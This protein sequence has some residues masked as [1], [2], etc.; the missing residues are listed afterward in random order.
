MFFIVGVTSRRKTVESGQFHC[1]YEAIQRR[2]R[3]VENRRYFTLFFVPL[4]PLG[5]QGAWV[6]CQG[7]GSTYEPGVLHQGSART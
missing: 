4:I 1:P 3:H 2:F 7:C 5:K 6:E